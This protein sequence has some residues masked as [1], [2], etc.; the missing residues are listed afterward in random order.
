[1]EKEPQSGDSPEQVSQE[2]TLEQPALT[3]PEARKA[4]IM[5]AIEAGELWSNERFLAFYI[6]R[7]DEIEAAG[8]DQ[9]FATFSFMRECGE[10][11]AAGG[12]FAEALETMQDL[13]DSAY[14]AGEIYDEF[15]AQV[16]LRILEL[17]IRQRFAELDALA[18][19]PG[20]L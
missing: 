19:P 8:G 9:E 15:V 5:A 7:Q 18:K 20:E 2:A 14:A 10:I 1:M 6:A 4:E 3:A 13:A 16:R 12:K 17:Q 11:Q